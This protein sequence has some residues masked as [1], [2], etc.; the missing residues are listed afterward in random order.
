MTGP[1]T[2]FVPREAQAAPTR[3]AE[4]AEGTDRRGRTGGGH[5]RR[6]GATKGEGRRGRRKGA[7]GHPKRASA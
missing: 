7:G 3:G 2:G 1:L 6:A 5:E 4:Q